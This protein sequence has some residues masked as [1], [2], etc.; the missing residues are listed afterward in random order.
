LPDGFRPGVPDV[1]FYNEAAELYATAK[2]AQA[3]E[4]GAESMRAKIASVW[5]DERISDISTPINPYKQ[6]KP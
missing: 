1:R 5:L 2:A 4:E 6:E 3:W